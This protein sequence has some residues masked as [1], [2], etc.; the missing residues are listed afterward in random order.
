MGSRRLGTATNGF[1]RFAALVALAASLAGRP[2]WSQS[3]RANFLLQMLRTSAEPRVR[4]N[5]ALRLGELRDSE[6]APALIELFASERDPLVRATII[7]SLAAIGDPR[8]LAT[9]REAARSSDRPV[10]QQGR[11]AIAILE[12]ASASASSA[13]Q[14]PSGVSRPSLLIA[15]GRVN[16]QAGIAGE[17]QASAQ[18]A[19]DAALSARPEVLRHTGAASTVAGVVR[20]QRLRGAHQFDANVQSVSAQSSGVRVAVSIVVSSLPGRA[21]E[22]DA[23]TA[24]TVAGGADPR[25]AAL[26]RAM[27][28]AVARAMTQLLSATR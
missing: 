8:A 23:S 27:A 20:A 1:G 5:A 22:F 25:A 3:A 13:E 12:R 17:L 2:S 4:V 6:A 18:R 24:V 10:A 19:L 9:A 14:P 26:D 21:Y 15:A 16:L 7:A 11:R 28:S